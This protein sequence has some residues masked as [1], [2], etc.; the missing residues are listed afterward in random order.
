[1]AALKPPL[2]VVDPS[3]VLDRWRPNDGAALRR[4]DLD[5]DT[6]RFF[7][8][9][10]KQAQAMPDSHSDSGGL[11]GHAVDPDLRIRILAH[12]LDGWH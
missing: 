9:T 11:P 3:F 4:F 6:A 1:M 8:Y 10:V 7:G 2:I 5:P 12:W